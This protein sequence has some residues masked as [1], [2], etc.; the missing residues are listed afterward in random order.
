MLVGNR[1]DRAPEPK[2]AYPATITHSE[3]SMDI[4]TEAEKQKRTFIEEGKKRKRQ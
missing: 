1:A 3:V 4:V 2:L